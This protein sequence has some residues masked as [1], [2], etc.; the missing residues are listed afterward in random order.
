[1]RKKVFI[2]YAHLDQEE[3]NW[4]KKLKK[5]LG[6]FERKETLDIWDD[7]KLKVGENPKDQI[8]NIINESKIAILLVGPE[9]LSSRFVNDIELPRILE[10]ARADGLKVFPLITNYCQYL[11]S[12]LREF[13]AYNDVNQPLESLINHQQ[14][15]T[16]HGFCNMLEEVYSKD[17][18]ML[19]S[20]VLAGSDRL[21]GF[22]QLELKNRRLTCCSFTSHKHQ[23]LCSGFEKEIFNVNLEN[24][25]IESLISLDSNSRVIF[26]FPDS[27]IFLVGYDNGDVYS[28]NSDLV[29]F[30]KCFSCESSVFSITYNSNDSTIITSERNGNVSEWKVNNVFEIINEEE[31]PKIDFLRLLIN[32]PSISFMFSIF[33]SR[34]AGISIGADGIIATINLQSGKVKKDNYY[35]NYSLYCIDISENNM[36]VIGASE[37]KVFLIDENYKRNEIKIHDDTVRSI[38]ITPKGN[39]LF[40]GS[41]DKTVKIRNLSTKKTWII[42]KSTDYI[43]E[44]K[45]SII[46]NQLLACDG[47]GNIFTFNF[48]TELDLLTS[49]NMDEI[50]KKK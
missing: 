20:E 49:N 39:W 46:Y 10:A 1:M 43:Y 2:S 41:K 9:F 50:L 48:D 3:I 14:N 8:I 37:G 12:E 28:V 34:K 35:S 32:R 16:L 18:Y 6:F 45:Y 36:I 15:K 27:S 25:S 11:K 38:C 31:T 21:F 5:H 44:V 30:E 47:S 17:D 7:S 33:S 13:W 4:I 23:I 42:F 26:R 29:D 19:F 24:K 22:Q 40:T